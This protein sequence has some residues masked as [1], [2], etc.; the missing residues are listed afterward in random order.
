MR[1]AHLLERDALDELLDAIRRQRGAEVIRDLGCRTASAAKGGAAEAV[2]ER[3]AA[4]TAWAAAGS[5]P[6]ARQGS[7]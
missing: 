6:G 1:S 5:S 3:R 4:A 7:T 2:I